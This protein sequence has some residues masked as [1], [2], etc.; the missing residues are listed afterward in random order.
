M[1]PEKTEIL[2]R[3]LAELIIKRFSTSFDY[4]VS[5]ALG[6]IIPG[7]ETARHLNVPALWTER[8]KGKMQLRRFSLP[9]KA[10]VIIVE[11]IV[12]TGLSMQETIECLTSLGV[13]IKGCACLIDRSC[14]P[15]RLDVPLISLT[16]Y[17]IP[18]YEEKALPPALSAIPAMKPGSRELF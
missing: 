12:T 6:G 14:A 9:K 15:V 3:A 13:E 16:R 18:V 7:Y 17:P 5:P 1:Y 11:D 2:C 8:E 10:R 4:V